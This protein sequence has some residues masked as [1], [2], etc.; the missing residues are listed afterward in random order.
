MGQEPEVFYG[1]IK[2]NLL[3]SKSDATLDEINYVLDKVNLLKLI[4]SFEKGIDSDVKN[5]SAGEK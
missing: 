3:I 5:L 2:D 4:Q 1:S